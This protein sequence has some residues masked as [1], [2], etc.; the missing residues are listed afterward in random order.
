MLTV[1]VP[2]I[3][4]G[5]ATFRTT[6][7][8]V[9]KVAA[10]TAISFMV[11][12]C[13]WPL[14]WTGQPMSALNTWIATMPGLAG[15]A[16]A[17]AWRPRSAVAYLIA[18]VTTVQVINHV[19]RV[20]A[21]NSPLLPDWLAAVGFCLLFLGASLMGMHT[22]RLLDATWAQ[23]HVEASAAAI[24]QARAAERRHFADLLHDWV[25]STLV[26]AARQ[27]PTSELERQAQLTLL[28]LDS[29]ST[30]SSPADTLTATDLVAYLQ[31]SAREVHEAVPIHVAMDCDADAEFPVDAAV[32][33]GTGIAEAVR[34][35]LRHAGPGCARL[36]RITVRPNAFNVSVADSG[37]GF[38]PATVSTD[39]HGLTEIRARMRQVP[40]GSA[41]LESSQD[42][43]TVALAWATPSRGQTPG[44]ADIRTIVGLTTQAAWVITAITLIGVAALAATSLNGIAVRWPVA[45][46]VTLIAGAALGLLKISGDPLPSL[47]AVAIAASVPMAFALVVAVLPVP[48]ASGAQ[49]WPPFAGMAVYA[50]MCVRGRIG[51]AWSGLAATI[52]VC[53]VWSILTRQGAA[54]A[55]EIMSGY[56]GPV[57]MG[58]FF[59]FTLRPNAQRIFALREEST[60]RSAHEAA[61]VASTD[62]RLDQLR[63]LDQRA[64]PMLERIAIGDRLS[65]ED[66]EA[67]ALLEAH[68]RSTLRGRGLVHPLVDSS[69]E[70]ARRRGVDVVLFDDKGMDD[71]DQH[72]RDRVLRGVA[73]EIAAARAGTIA[74][75][76]LPPHAKQLATVVA[77]SDTGVRRVAFDSRGR[78]SVSVP[79]QQS[80]PD[81]TLSPKTGTS[82]PARQATYDLPTQ[83]RT[84]SQDGR[85][86]TSV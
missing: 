71:T 5:A 68:L 8:R 46:A 30:E 60:R 21:S 11:A 47:P 54:Y 63:R 24:V 78:A 14:A 39:R 19:A 32:A 53:V 52:A 61:A 48:I 42:G 72:T 16:A 29:V 80:F 38:D 69:A 55:V 82:T 44:A 20:P 33:V 79:R 41:I 34:N 75:R 31:E 37:M 62:E 73:E 3:V 76:I 59:A 66:R 28:K 64:R 84:D 36:V 81:V 27:P 57:A 43:T 49:L 23:D 85:G 74:I 45:I 13:A 18:A 17:I 77:R 12:A 9:R 15:L 56:I 1:F 10:L 51:L 26:A 2:A 7:S 83:S 50:F 22:A 6:I 35:S 4:L 86:S 70:A 65:A 25:M 40:G 58:T 67:C